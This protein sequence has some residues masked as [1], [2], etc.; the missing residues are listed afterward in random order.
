M[1]TGPN[2]E[3]WSIDIVDPRIVTKEEILLNLVSWAVLAPSSHNVQPWRFKVYPEGNSI[4]VCLHKSGV[5][6]HSDPKGRQANISIGC[7]LQN[8]LTAAE[9]YGLETTTE[10]YPGNFYPVPLARLK[11][12]QRIGEF[13]KK[14]RKTLDAMKSRKMNRGKFDPLQD[15]PEYIFD[16]M[17][18]AAEDRKLALNVVT[19]TPTK[20]AIAEIQ[21][22]ADRSVIAINNF[23]K[24][25]GEF[26]LPN[27]TDRGIGMPGNTFG[28]SDEMA[29]YAHEE[30]NKSGPF[31]PDLAFG[32]AASGRDGLKSSPLIG[33][34]SVS[35]DSPVWWITAGMT[36]QKIA[37]EAEMNGLA[38]AVHAAI[39][40]VEMFNRLLK[41][42]LRQNYRPT[43]IFRM[44]YAQEERPHS[45]RLS[46]SEV[47]EIMDKG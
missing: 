13:N 21:Y 20:F 28:L 27:D 11:F 30:F 44:G 38:V 37:L 7:A 47:S 42:R 35:E 43:V 12:G 39:V 31:D 4:D 16:R 22:S 25:L 14:E 26:F 8:I 36:F 19:D 40:E 17:R 2:F 32:I 24:E 34:I 15:V 6:K 46:V 1:R 45:P 29:K 9:Y 18:K 10:Y 3:A 41:V 33:F 5:L 23:R